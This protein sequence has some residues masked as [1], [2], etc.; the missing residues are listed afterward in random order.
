MKHDL[1][2]I[3]AIVVITVVS[4][5]FFYAC[6]DT[7][8]DSRRSDQRRLEEQLKVIRDM[9]QQVSCQDSS[10]WKF[11]AIGA[12]GCGGPSGYI[13]YSVKIDTTAFMNK[14]KAYTREEQEFNKKW[15]IISPCN[16][17]QAPKE[18]TCENG[19]A[20]LVY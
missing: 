13:S 11:T 16:L 7:L 9:S 6:K 15:N 10:E 17:I 4:F 2:K 1:Q 8:E 3:Y 20:R 12:R 19:K 14:V 18:V 5:S